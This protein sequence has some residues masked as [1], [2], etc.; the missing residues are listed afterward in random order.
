MK[1]VYCQEKYILGELLVRTDREVVGGARV[2]PCNVTKGGGQEL[3]PDGLR[4]LSGDGGG[5]MTKT[6]RRAVLHALI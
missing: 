2:T 4:E 3:K 5:R 1:W 6:L